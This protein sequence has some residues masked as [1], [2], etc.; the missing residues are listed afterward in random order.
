MSD[1]YVVAAGKTVWHSKEDKYYS[2][3]QAIDLSHLTDSE[4]ASV[5]ASG[6]VRVK[7]AADLK[8]EAQGT[9]VVFG[10]KQKNYD[11]ADDA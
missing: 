5:L 10:K 7:Q 6:A 4:Q 1:V 9:P 8:A 2:E 11:K 3:G